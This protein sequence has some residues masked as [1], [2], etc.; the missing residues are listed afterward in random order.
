MNLVAR[1]KHLADLEPDAR[2]HETLFRRPDGLVIVPTSDRLLEEVRD[3][4]RDG[5][6]L[7]SRQDLGAADQV[8]G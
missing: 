1:P 3:Q 7:L 4:G 5:R 2:L 8:L 6:I